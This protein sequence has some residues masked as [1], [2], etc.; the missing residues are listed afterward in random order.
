MKHQFNKSI[1]G[2]L[3]LVFSGAALGQ[4]RVLS[5]MEENAYD[6]LFLHLN[7][8]KNGAN[9][10]APFY[11][12]L[13]DIYK[14]KSGRVTVFHMGDSH[15]DAGYLTAEARRGLQEIFGDA[16]RG[17]IRPR[18]KKRVRL[19]GRYR[20]MSIAI[21]QPQEMTLA[22]FQVGLKETDPSAGFDQLVFFHEKG[23]EYLDFLVL[24]PEGKV[25]GQVSSGQTGFNPGPTPIQL[26][27]LYREVTVWAIRSRKSQHLVQLYGISLEN[28]HPGLL[29]HSYGVIGAEYS[30]VILSNFVLNQ[31]KFINPDLV[32]VSLGTN[33]SFASNFSE[34]AFVAN[35]N[36]LVT[37]IRLQ[38]PQA[39]IILSTAADSYQR[40]KRKSRPLANA[41]N[42]TVCQAVSRYCLANNLSCWDLFS[43][44]GSYGSMR[45]WKQ[46]MLGGSDLI[47]F[48]KAGYDLQGKLLSTAILNGFWDYANTR[49]N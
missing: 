42:L 16:S 2:L 45:Q 4:N 36:T 48:T 3:F 27:R 47:H 40:P 11:A 26:D 44:M 29:Y 39:A 30:N 23:E 41:N 25:L 12:K 21:D 7:Y 5:P 19:R 6:F 31:L 33:D 32:I 18:V 8:L 15:I 35:L 9:S 34:S 17:L 22:R 24:S 14:S 13:Y 46:V 37:A 10:L 1:I 20:D 38:A 28:N 43:I 49:S